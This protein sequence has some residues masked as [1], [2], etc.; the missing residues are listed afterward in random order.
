MT[1]SDAPMC[2]DCGHFFN[3]DPQV[4]IAYTFLYTDYVGSMDTG[5]RAYAV[6]RLGFLD[7]FE[8]VVLDMGNDSPDKAAGAVCYALVR[9]G[10]PEP[11][12]LV[13]AVLHRHSHLDQ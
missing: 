12:D 7:D 3:D 4:G 13:A 6:G 1:V 2:H 9:G 11:E 5:E 8:E 10:W